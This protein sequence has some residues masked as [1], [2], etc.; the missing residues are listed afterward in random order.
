MRRFGAAVVAGLSLLSVCMLGAPAGAA[1]ASCTKATF[2]SNQKTS[3]ATSVLSG[4][5]G[6]PATGATLVANFK[7]LTNITTTI[8]W[9]NKAGVS[10]PFKVTEKAGPKTSTCKSE[11]VKGKSVK[12]ALIVS[13]GVVTASTGK[14]AGLKGSKFSESLCVTQKVTTYLE[15]GTKIVI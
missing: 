5:T 7:V 9:N 12:D 13:S 2:S 6:G 3:T 10:G 8:T 14:A 4:C 11:I 15:P 1:S